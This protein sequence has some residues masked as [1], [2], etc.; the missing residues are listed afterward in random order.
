MITKE[1]AYRKVEQ[2]LDKIEYDDKYLIDKNATNDHERGWVIYYNSKIYIETKDVEFAL[3]GNAPFLVRKDTGKV[4]ATG[5]SEPVEFYI[6]K[7][8]SNKN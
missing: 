4:V 2:L 3:M 8:I 7:Y 6:D 5:T 1:E